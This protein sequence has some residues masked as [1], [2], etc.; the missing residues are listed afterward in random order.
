MRH[1]HAGRVRRPEHRQGRSTYPLERRPASLLRLQ[2]RG[3]AATSPTCLRG[4]ACPAQ[5]SC[6]NGKRARS[7]AV[8]S[9]CGCW[10]V[11]TIRGRIPRLASSLATGES[12]MASGRVP[13]TSATRWSYSSPLARRRTCGG[14]QASWQVSAEVVCVGLKSSSARASAR[15]DGSGCPCARRRR[16]PLRAS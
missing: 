9:R 15:S 2:D 8:G 16:S 11:R 13:M 1:R 10:P 14:A 6:A 5:P 3:F 7:N 12:L 4:S